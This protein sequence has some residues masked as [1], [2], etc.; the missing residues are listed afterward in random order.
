MA[1]FKDLSRYIKGKIRKKIFDPMLTKKSHFFEKFFFNFI[2]YDF[3]LTMWFLP[4]HCDHYIWGWLSDNYHEKIYFSN[5]RDPLQET[6]LNS[7]SWMNSAFQD[8]LFIIMEPGWKWTIQNGWS[9]RFFHDLLV[10]K[11]QIAFPVIIST[12]RLHV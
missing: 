12:S 3:I 4:D 6:S 1:Y 9:K 8:Q 11:S 10:V 2:E 7:C 5:E